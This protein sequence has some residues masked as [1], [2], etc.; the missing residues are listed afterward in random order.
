MRVTGI[1]PA[2]LTRQSH[3]ERPVFPL[4]QP[5]ERGLDLRHIAHRRHAR[6]AATQLSGGLW[7]PQQQLAHNRQLLRIELEIAVLRVTEAVLILRHPT[8]E[9]RLLYHEVL[10]RQAVHR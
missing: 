6:R 4:T 2:R 3:H 8:A 5:R 1:P 10:A 7:P 9:A